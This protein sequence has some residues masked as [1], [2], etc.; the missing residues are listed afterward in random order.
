MLDPDQALV[1]FLAKTWKY[2]RQHDLRSALGIE[3]YSGSP[4]KAISC[5]SGWVCLPMVKED[6]ARRPLLLPPNLTCSTFIQ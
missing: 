6:E 3:Q 2:Q 4:E 5:P 1:V